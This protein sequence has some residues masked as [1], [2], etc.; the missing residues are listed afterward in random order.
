MKALFVII[1]LL[2]ASSSMAA[3]SEFSKF[4]DSVTMKLS[5]L[6]G[7][8]LTGDVTAENATFAVAYESADAVI[9]ASKNAFGTNASQGTYNNLVLRQPA[10]GNYFMIAATNSEPGAVGEQMNL[11]GRIVSKTFRQDRVADPDDFKAFLRLQYDNLIF[12]SRLRWPEGS[13]RIVVSNI[14]K[15]DTLEKIMIELIL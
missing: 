15:E 11:E 14:G 2:T 6:I 5:F 1:V 4:G 9:L 8:S 13:S 7:P 3:T 10:G 12:A